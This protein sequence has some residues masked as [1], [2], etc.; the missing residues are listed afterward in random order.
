MT[1]SFTKVALPNGWLG[2]MA[3]Y[4]VVY[5]GQTWR[6]TEALFQALRFDDVHIREEIRSQKSPIAAKMVA[7]RNQHRMVVIPKSKQ[8]LANMQT[9]LK[10]KFDQ[11]PDLKDRLLRTGDEEI[12]E[13]VSE[14]TIGGENNHL[15]WGAA[16]WDGQWVGENNLGKLW[17]KLREEYTDGL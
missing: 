4:L 11:H 7:K 13:D 5:D 8:D 2:N 12:I 6:T 9:V 10:L 3:P 17:M 1:I 14:R 15:F 16:L